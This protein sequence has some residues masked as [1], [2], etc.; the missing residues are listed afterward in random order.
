MRIYVQADVSP[1]RIIAGRGLQEGG[2]V[3]EHI[4]KEVKRLA[5]KYVPAS[6]GSSAHMKGR[7]RIAGGGR[8][9]IYPGPYAHY[10]HE[11][12]VM[13]GSAPKHYNGKALSY[14]DAPMRGAHWEKRMMAD[15]KDE[16][17]D[18]VESY[19]RSLAK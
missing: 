17:E 8:Y 6:A 7:A 3:N 2:P 9:L 1:S 18:S 5:D 11:G 10:Q 14:H 15:C 13:V 19:I 4:A 16:L 12:L